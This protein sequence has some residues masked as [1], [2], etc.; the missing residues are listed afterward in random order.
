MKGLLVAAQTGLV[1]EDFV[2]ARA[3]ENLAAGRCN[4]LTLVSSCCFVKA[5]AIFISEDFVAVWAGKDLAAGASLPSM[6]SAVMFAQA[7]LID[8]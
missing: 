3:A 1:D 6:G 8:K 7:W 4:L 5:Q 2:A